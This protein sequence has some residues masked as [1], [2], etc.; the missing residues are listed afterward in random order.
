MTALNEHSATILIVDDLAENIEV[1]GTLIR[2]NKYKVAVAMNGEEAIAVAKKILPDLILL[3]IAMPGRDGFSVCKTLK[4]DP[5]TENIPVIFLTAKVESEDIV[6]GFSLGAVDYITKP[7]K[8]A[9]LLMR[10]KTHLTIKNLQNELRLT[11][12][13]LE[14]KV[15]ERTRELEKAKEKAELSDNLKSEFLSSISHEIR[16]PLNAVISSASLIESEM[17]G[18]IDEYLKPI[19]ESLKKGSYRIIRTVDLVL[20]M[21]QLHTNSYQIKMEKLDVAEILMLVSSK[22]KSAAKEKKV[23]LE[24]NDL[25]KDAFVTADYYAVVEIFE[26]LLDN[27]VNFTGKGS[28]T[29]SLAETENEYAASVEDSGAGIGGEYLTSLFNYFSQEDVGYTRK[30]EGNGLGLALTKR[31]CDLIKASISVE[32]EKGKGSKFTVTFKKFAP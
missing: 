20:N 4:C 24:I 5:V 23:A 29:V 18:K 1:L 27:A 11:N 10:V 12:E 30:F 14:E 16:T 31:Y 19:F 22:Y 26:Q 25:I 3:D 2:K 28:I 15:I 6:A 7:F 32:S 13:R 21:A 9:E 17:E 8:S